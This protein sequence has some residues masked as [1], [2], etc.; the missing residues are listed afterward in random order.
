[1]AFFPPLKNVVQ[2]LVELHLFDPKKIMGQL[3]V[4][5]HLL[6]SL[7]DIASDNLSSHAGCLLSDG[8]ENGTM[9]VAHLNFRDLRLALVKLKQRACFVLKS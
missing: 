3:T 2:N 6:H 7:I 4:Y 8:R 5:V 9:N 1:M